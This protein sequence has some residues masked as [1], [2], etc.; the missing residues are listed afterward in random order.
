MTDNRTSSYVASEMP[1]GL[2]IELERL[3][4][5]ALLSWAKEAHH[6]SGWGLRD[7]MQILE[8][9]SGPGFI[10]EQLARFVPSGSVTSLEID[11]VLIEKAT[12]YMQTTGLSNWRI[13]EGNVMHMDLPD[14]TFDFVYARYLFQHLPDPVGAAKE[15][16]RVL[17]PGGK[18]VITDVDDKLDIFDPESSP[19]VMAIYERIEKSH[20]DTQASKGGNRFIGRRLPNILKAAGYESLDLEGVLIHNLVMDLSEFMP[21]PKR[22]DSQHQVDSGLITDAELDLMMEDSVRFYE[23][24][25][26]IFLP[27]M[28]ACGQKPA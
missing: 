20:Q 7:G 3:R 25:Y 22:E 5:Q 2:D 17:K 14:N 23:A 16:M 1:R 26:V 13:V 6:L 18:L 12:N 10:T 21:P 24:D 4:A 28:M 11:P 8:I 27:L 19:E 15:A 9:G